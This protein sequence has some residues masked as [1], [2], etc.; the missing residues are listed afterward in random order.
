[1]QAAASLNSYVLTSIARCENPDIQPENPETQ[2]DEMRE[3]LFR[4]RMWSYTTLSFLKDP[5]ESKLDRLM[6]I[7]RLHTT[8]QDRNM[9]VY[10]SALMDVA[11]FVWTKAHQS[12]LHDRVKDMFTDFK[13][14]LRWLHDRR[15][16]PGDD[17]GLAALLEDA[18]KAIAADDRFNYSRKKS[19]VKNG[20]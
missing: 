11:I 6:N 20:V 15:F 18:V 7:A 13:L 4:L 3:Q 12:I 2:G 9:D 10:W 17:E 5:D 16:A 19:R 1:M 8:P 14:L